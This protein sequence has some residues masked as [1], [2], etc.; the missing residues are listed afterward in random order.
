MQNRNWARRRSANAGEEKSSNGEKANILDIELH[1]GF[2]CGTT[3][4]SESYLKSTTFSTTKVI[5][6][7]ISPTKRPPREK[8]LLE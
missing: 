8:I 6:S 4:V 2:S 5:N 7:A 1:G 3:F